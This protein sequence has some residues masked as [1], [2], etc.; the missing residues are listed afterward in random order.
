M[1]MPKANVILRGG[2]ASQLPEGER[3]R[4][5]ADAAISLKLPRGNRYEHFEPS[6]ETINHDGVDLQVFTW[7][8]VTYVAE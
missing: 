1:Q 7:T 2:P 4:Y 6:P 3:V 8:R 5:V